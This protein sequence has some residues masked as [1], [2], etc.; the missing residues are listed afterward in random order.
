[1]TVYGAN[2]TNTF[3][4]PVMRRQHDGDLTSTTT[5]QVRRDEF[6]QFLLETAVARGATVVKGDADGVLRDGDA[7]CGLRV[8][9]AEGLREFP[10]RIL[11]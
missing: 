3:W 4:V 2:G 9:T 10:C 5:W 1:M 6:D 11:V 7:V 8:K